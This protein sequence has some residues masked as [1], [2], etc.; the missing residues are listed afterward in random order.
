M[1]PVRARA[2]ERELSVPKNGRVGSA[3]V[4]APAAFSPATQGRF[5][6]PRS[7]PRCEARAR[8]G[9]RAAK[10][11]CG[12]RHLPA[13][14]SCLGSVERCHTGHRAA[15]EARLAHRSRAIGARGDAAPVRQGGARQRRG[16]VRRASRRAARPGRA[17]RGRRARGRGASE[18]A[19]EARAGRA[20]PTQHRDR[21]GRG[22]GAARRGAQLAQLARGVEPALARARPHA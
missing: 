19:L 17:P 3:A 1:R 9:H 12:P 18:Q 11:G 15:R 2:G 14:V 16:S 4:G 21:R 10:E 7:G 22:C 13:V 8:R 5:A 6:G 20:T